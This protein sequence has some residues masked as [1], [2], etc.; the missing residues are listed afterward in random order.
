MRFLA[1]GLFLVFLLLGV[2]IAVSNT[3]R[4]E[5][6]LWPIPH[7]V[8]T[9]TADRAA[10]LAGEVTIPGRTNQS[11]SDTLDKLAPDG[12]G[13]LEAMRARYGSR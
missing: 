3:E 2:L 5:L 11:L 12:H 9:L 7:T 10:Q 1:R 8:V 13:S 6:A 4:T